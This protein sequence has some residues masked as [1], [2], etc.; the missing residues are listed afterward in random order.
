[1]LK[2]YL[3]C[4]NYLILSKNDIYVM[5]KDFEDFKVFITIALK[6]TKNLGC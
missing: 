4:E 3:C 5:F 2:F 1:M 6:I